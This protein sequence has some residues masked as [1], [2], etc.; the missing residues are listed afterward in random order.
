MSE[1]AIQ[2]DN[3]NSKMFTTD[4]AL[5]KLL[6]DKL[7]FR[8][9]NYW[10]STAYKKKKWDGWKYF[11]SEKTG[12][13][14]TGILPEIKAALNKLNKKY[15]IVDVRKNFEWGQQ[16]I[17]QDFLIPST[18]KGVEAFEMYDYQADLVNQCIKYN[19]GIIQSPTGSGKTLILL[20]LIKCLK[21]KTPTLFIT[22]NAQLVHQNWEEMKL[23]GVEGLGRWY[24]K[25][26]EPNYVMCVTNHFKTF[27]SLDK[28]LPKFKVLIVDEVHD[29]MS[30]VP[31]EA[32]RKMKSASVRIGISAT[33]FKWDKKKIDNVHKWNLKGHFGP[34]LKT[35]TTESGI[36]TTKGLQERSILS[37][38][39]CS[40]YHVTHPNL[41]HE[42]YQD[43]VKLGIE[44][45]F[46]FHDM[47]KKLA[48]SCTGRTLIVV[49]RIEQGQYLNQLIKGSHFIQ[50]KDSLKI[51]VPIINSLKS[52]EKS[53]AIIMRQIITAGIDIKI[54]DLINAAGGDG[55]HNI[56][57]L[58]GR[59]LRNADDKESLRYHDFIFKIN[60][61]LES[62]SNWRVKVLEKEGHNVEIKEDFNL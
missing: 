35:T 36:L 52:G 62:H 56:I 25:Y 59:G 28:L 1:I 10:H 9:K 49:E 21:P 4:I 46:H 54:H 31:I 40:F 20:S 50:G 8:P 12:S 42:P 44:Q 39:N 7:R 15:T 37:S 18:P 3:I 61:Y 41:E 53:V 34:I 22:K 51:R 17:K 6:A 23:W 33:S 60:D 55:A 14:L 38:S 11:F 13:F 43:A 5:K 2:I 26:K 57:Q 47:V 45:N 27:E 24:D 58:I 19:R 29:C 30:D 32:Y 48:D 16:E